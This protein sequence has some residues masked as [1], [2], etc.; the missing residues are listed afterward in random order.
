MAIEGI[1]SEMLAVQV[2]EFNQPYKIHKVPTPPA[3]KEYE[4]LLKT[5]VASLCHTDFMVLEGKFPTQ[6]PC[7]ASHEGTG[8]VKAVGSK[9]NNFKVGDRVMSGV[10]KNACGKCYNCTGPNDWHQYCPNL[11]GHIGVF[12]NGAFAEYHVVDSRTSCHIPDQVS[13]ASAAPLACAGCTIYRALMVS[14]VKG[15]EWLAIVGAGGGLG[16][17]GIQFAQAKGINVVAID[18]RD[19]ALALCKE[20]G[21][22]HIFDARDGQEKVVE[23][24]QALT[25]GLGVHAAI[26][27][28]DHPTAA[29]TA[30]AVTRMHGTMVQAAQPDRVSV[31]FQE[32]VFRDIRIKGTLIAGQDYSQQMLNDAAKH[33]IKVETNLFYGLDAVPKMLELAHSGK[34]QGKAVCVVDQAEFERDTATV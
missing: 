30:C 34:M 16:H 17:L 13:F 15:G 32:L 1:P 3:L 25:D 27:V 33:N 9:V 18:A 2:V 11:E 6:L 10:P 21:A 4:I 24:V 20:V 26:N 28:S 7:T 12:T 22:K 14:S 31:A 8:I 5:V 29:D 23:R 19:E